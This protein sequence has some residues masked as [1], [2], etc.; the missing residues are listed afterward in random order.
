MSFADIRVHAV[1]FKTA[2]PEE[3]VPRYSTEEPEAWNAIRRMIER[4]WQ[5]EI[6]GGASWWE[7]SFTW[8]G[9]PT[10]TIHNPYKA[11][12]GSN[13]F[14]EAVCTAILQAMAPSAPHLTRNSELY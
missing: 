8:L 1:L 11:Y 3:P 10:G 4:G 7:V 6:V 12:A 9:K 5:V 2:P 13:L 14:P